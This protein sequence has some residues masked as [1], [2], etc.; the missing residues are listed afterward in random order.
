MQPINTAVNEAAA[1][2]GRESG[3]GSPELPR[4]VLWVIRCFQS[5]AV[6]G[7]RRN[8]LMPGGSSPRSRQNSLPRT[9]ADARR[10][11]LSATSCRS[12]R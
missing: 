8:E 11:A 4:G 5:A 9:W 10:V 2:A 6:A 3:S 12:V 1:K 7:E